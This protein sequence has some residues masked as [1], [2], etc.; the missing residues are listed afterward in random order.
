M[1]VNSQ[2]INLMINSIIKIQELILINNH[3]SQTNIITK[4]L[5]NINTNNM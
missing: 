4:M 3:H 2:T 1:G 5:H